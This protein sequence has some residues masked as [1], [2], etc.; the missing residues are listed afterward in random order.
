MG[1]SMDREINTESIRA[2]EK[3]IEEGGGD[4]IKL[5]RARNSLLN[6]STRVPPEIL[7]DIFTWTLVRQGGPASFLG[8]HFSGLCKGSY[9]F[10]LVCHHWFGV[11]SRTPEL[12]S[13]W[14]N[15][16]QQ[17][18]KRHH[19][20]RNVLLDLVLN[21]HASDPE[22][23]LS[24]PLRDA[25]RARTTQD[26]IRQV[27]LL[28]HNG[29]LLSSVISL[30][31]PDEEY[32]QHKSIESIDLR[33]W[34]TFI[35][36]VSRFFTCIRLPKL[37][38]LFLHGVLKMPS[39]DH[40]VEQT[41]L[42]TTLSLDISE[43]S[44]TQSPT[45][46]LLSMLDS[47]PSLRVLSLGG[48]AIPE[49][50]GGW[51]TS[52][53]SLRHLRK[54]HLAGEL[55]CVFRLLNRLAFPDTLDS[56]VFTVPNSTVEDLSQILKPR[57]RDYLRRDH[58]PQ[59]KLVI[60]THA[61]RNHLLIRISLVGE[62]PSQSSF[63][64]EVRTSL[65]RRAPPSVVENLCLDL[66]AFTPR[67]RV[68]HFDTNLPTNRLEDLLFKM[69]NIKTLSLY[70]ATVSNGF[71][72]PNSHGPR[73]GTK[74]LPS[75]RSLYLEN[76]TLTDDWGNLQTYLAHQTSDGQAI[77]LKIR[78]FSHLC[79]EVAQEIMDLVKG[80]DCYLKPVTECP[81][82]RCGLSP[83]ERSGRPDA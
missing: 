79:P 41:T 51:P 47:N 70:R 16:L 63:F 52:Q 28:S 45:T 5:K 27:H 66:I 37:R 83:V 60:K 6:I 11:A 55:R 56:M 72:Q 1:S 22:S 10:L 75:L 34:G 18:G 8:P 17:W 4:T 12:W 29:E 33:N 9:N 46:E 38:S 39:W 50:D 23:W 35:S 26:T 82:G 49:D 40:L 7:G 48:F 36:D 25:L 69:P 19:Y 80:F 32:I 68:C 73:A 15:T 61:T 3:Q 76:V 67:G 31:T 42:L 20:S 71:L 58:M 24:G 2:L 30:L 43:P 14:G 64:V 65:A 77:S 54:L 13:F 74:L 21:G 57:L 53:V 62:P 44:L 78:G 59:D 81:F